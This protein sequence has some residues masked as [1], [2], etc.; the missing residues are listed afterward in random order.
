MAERMGMHVGVVYILYICTIYI[1]TPKRK[2]GE[3]KQHGL[4]KILMLPL[5][6]GFSE[7]CDAIHESCMYSTCT[8]T[9][10]TLGSSN[11]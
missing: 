6:L 5:T 2:N 1:S 8:S 3:V 7:A 10:G 9:Q 4:Q 11:I